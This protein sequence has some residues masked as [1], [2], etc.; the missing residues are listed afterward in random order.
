MEIA[1]RR[2]ICIFMDWL[3]KDATIFLERKFLRY[4]GI[5]RKKLDNRGKKYDNTE[6]TI[7]KKIKN[8][9]EII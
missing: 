1:G 8:K 7:N 2:Q 6:L 9:Y 4:V 5:K 3:Y